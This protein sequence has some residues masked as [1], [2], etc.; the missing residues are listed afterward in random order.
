MT[1][2]VDHFQLEPG[3]Q[4]IKQGE[5]ARV[6]GGIW[7]DVGHAYLTDQ[8]F[9]YCA[10]DGT[11]HPAM[12]PTRI[13]L[14]IPRAEVSEVTEAR[15]MLTRKFV[16]KQPSGALHSF[17]THDAAAWLAAFQGRSVEAPLGP[18]PKRVPRAVKAMLFAMALGGAMLLGRWL[19]Q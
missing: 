3:E 18:P 9:V 16:V 2:P 10:G 12:P 5:V 4:L 13:A 8:R 14:V 15:Q 6:R 11:I 17:G 19:R 1:Q 7:G